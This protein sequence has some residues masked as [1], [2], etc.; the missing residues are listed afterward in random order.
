MLKN[1]TSAP[2]A[3]LD[4]L[5]LVNPNLLAV[6]MTQLTEAEI[7]RVAE[8][9]TTVIHCPESNLKLA[10]GF[11]PTQ[12]L[13]SQQARVIIGTDSCASNDD[14]DMFSEMR[15]AAL[16][17]KGVSLQ[18]TAF[19]AEQALRAATIDAAKAFRLD[20]EIGSL[21]P[22]KSADIIAINCDNIEGQPIY[23]LASH[24]VYSCERS[25]VSDVFISGRQLLRERS[26]TTISE[27][28]ILAKTE[29]WA[30]KISD[31]SQ[32]H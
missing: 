11:C 30:G 18:A 25:R 8:A 19:P 3:R 4:E 21:E 13:L 14:L 24:L 22:G 10:S 29:A 26:L 5:G 2:L 12:D 23:D 27:D 20:D 1:L 9:G 7:E 17:A 6:H 31:T 28:E 32:S 15:T 16:L